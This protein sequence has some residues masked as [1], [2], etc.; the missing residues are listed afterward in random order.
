MIPEDV[1]QQ[2]SI[3]VVCACGLPLVGRYVSVQLIGQREALTLCEVE[4]YGNPQQLIQRTMQ[5]IP[6]TGVI[7][8][9]LPSPVTLP[10]GEIVQPGIGPN[11][12]ILPS[13]RT[14]YPQPGPQPAP[15]TL[16]SGQTAVPQPYY[17]PV[18]YDVENVAAN[19]PARQ[20][21]TTAGA[22]PERAVDGDTNSDFAGNSCTQ[23]KREQNSY[24]VVDLL[25]PKDVY[26]VTITNRKD[27]CD[28]RIKG[29]EI[30]VGNSYDISDND[31]CGNFAISGTTAYQET[32]DVYCG[33]GLPVRGRYVSVQIPNKKQTLTLCEVEV[34]AHNV[35]DLT[36][37]P[38]D[39]GTAE[40]F[41][42]AP[43]AD[44]T[45][46]EP[47]PMPPDLISIATE[48]P[49][50]QSSLQNGGVP[51]RAVD[52]NRNTDFSGKSCTKTKKEYQ[53]WWRVD[54]AESRDVY[55][56]TI[57]NR[58]D[59][60][61]FKLKNAEVR[62][63]DSENI[64][65]NTVCGQRVSGRVSLQETIEVV[66][67]CGEP[68]RGRY[69][70]IQLQN[71]TQTLTL[72]EVD[73]WSLDDVEV[74]TTADTLES[75]P[76]PSDLLN[77]AE[78]RFATQ[79][80][81]KGNGDANRAVDK[82]SNSWNLPSG[83]CSQTNKEHEAWWQVDLGK[84]RDIY[85]VTITNRADC[86]SYRLKNAEVVIGH[87]RSLDEA[88][89]CGTRITGAAANEKKIDVICSCGK[90]ITGRFVGVYLPNTTQSLTLC[91]VEVWAHGPL[92]FTTLEPTTQSAMLRTTVD[93]C[94]VPDGLVNIAEGKN[95]F[96]S[97]EER[98][99][100]ALR[101][102]DGDKNSDFA[103]RSCTLTSKEE[104]PWWKLDLGRSRDIYHVTI[105]N[106]LDCCRGLR[107]AEIRV[108]SHDDYKMN[109]LCGRITADDSALETID[110]ICDCGQ[111]ISGRFISVSLPSSG[112]DKSLNLCE[113]EVFAFYQD[114]SLFTT[115]LPERCPLPDGL[116]DIAKDKPVRQSS[117]KGPNKPTRAVDGIKNSDLG[118]KSCSQT[119]KESEPWW[120]L[121]LGNSYDVYKVVITNRFDCCSYR[122]KNAEVRVGESPTILDNEMC[123][124]ERITG[125]I[126]EQKTIN[127]MCGCREPIRGRYVSIQIADKNQ[128]LALCEV[129]VFVSGGEQFPVLAD[130]GGQ[131]EMTCPFPEG[132]INSAQGMSAI[133]SSENRGGKAKRAVDGTHNSDYA[134]KSCTQTNK[135]EEPYWVVDLGKTRTVYEVI[136]TNRMDCC[137]FRL[138]GAEIRVG[139]RE[140]F[141]E[142]KLCRYTTI[143]G[144]EA[145]LETVKVTCECGNPG[146][147][148]YVSIQI[149]GKKQIL[150]LCEV[151]VWTLPDELEMPTTLMPTT[152][153]PT[154]TEK[155]CYVPARAENVA[156]HKPT[157]TSSVKQR[158]KSD[159]V[160]DGNKNSDFNDGSC[161]LTKKEED[162]WWMVDLGSSHNVWKVVITNRM[163]CC[164]FKLDG[165]EIRVGDDPDALQDNA[166]C[167]TRLTKS[168]VNKIE[169]I[170]LFCK[171]DSYLTGR[172]VSVQLR[173][174]VRNLS[175]CEVEIFATQ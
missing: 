73:V 169:T 142:N 113:V 122:I 6:N 172:Y 34:W 90:P 62:I 32:I 74:T 119:E 35:L 3:D 75:C 77:V 11:P 44:Y 167:D 4:V 134:G 59:C 97:S 72:C 117:T 103:G 132:L 156:L 27:C 170:E 149:V 137:S 159:R 162:P 93:P 135:E 25:E 104:E 40:P 24:W 30:H 150:S 58:Q 83:S 48:M 108:G 127:V 175:L 41:T 23:T 63:G 67:K 110:V 171:C 37:A 79:S 99:A 64:A 2:E 45:T 147:G 126:A 22:V 121:D 131:G 57:T 124:E 128:M 160:V 151:E 136:I 174:I 71:K 102:V 20:S 158:A 10:S 89:L 100:N 51:E 106:R 116:E 81:T 153:P 5:P 154:T 39:W 91:E 129:Q 85:Y 86:C 80:S 163:D 139:N 36:A 9:L 13:G 87:T 84:S 143:T 173:Q 105:T 76:V 98:N 68:I 157:S 49:A 17:C 61:P 43:D 21:S 55:M 141:R 18:P 114:E 146:R 161:S 168:G 130:W 94:P 1:V 31:L 46:A 92:E 95:A 66:C 155:V 8:P 145:S 7:G 54:L 56:I 144:Q 152:L 29:A 166:L 70:S 140:D 12:V 38:I 78:D 138:K 115:V 16:P 109:G 111:P 53:P 123:G 19:M 14:V 65:E 96:Q 118:G 15:V 101:A 82:N 50:T 33:C 52:D 165:A 125:D 112:R 88:T 120:Q 42:F 28:F 47:C 60:C 148:R 69:V 26:L 164:S 133:Q 107:N